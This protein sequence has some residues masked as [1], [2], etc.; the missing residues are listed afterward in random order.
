MFAII[1]RLL[2][3]YRHN[4]FFVG[5]KITGTGPVINKMGQAQLPDVFQPC[6]HDSINNRLI[7]IKTILDHLFGYFIGRN[8]NEIILSR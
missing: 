5:Q 6:Q 8:F 3:N 4:I 7:D 2:V 1:P